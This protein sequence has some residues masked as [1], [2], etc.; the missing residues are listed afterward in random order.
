VG[1]SAWSRDNLSLEEG[2]FHRLFQ[3]VQGRRM[4]DKCKLNEMFDPD[5]RSFF[6]MRTQW[7]RLPR[8]AVQSPSMEV[9]SPSWMLP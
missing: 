3:V 5:I 9:S 8:K 2:H 7:P 4:G 1:S 6:P